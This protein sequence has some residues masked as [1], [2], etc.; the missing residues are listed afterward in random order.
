MNAQLPTTE[1]SGPPNVYPGFAHFALRALVPGTTA[2]CDIRLEAI[3]PNQQGPRLVL[4]LSRHAEVD[5]SWQQ[6]LLQS[7]VTHAFTPLED[8]D[9]LL[10]YLSRQS[11]LALTGPVGA[12]PMQGHYLAYEH[13][14]CSLKA[15]LLDPRNGRRLAL[16]AS[17]VRKLVGM[18][19]DND[20]TRQAMLKVLSRDQELA[21]HGLNTCLLAVGFA[22]SLGWS[23]LAA[24]RLGLAM[25]YHDLGLVD[26]AHDGPDDALWGGIREGKALEDH[27]RL[28]RDFLARIEDLDPGVPELVYNHHENL[29]GSGY[30]RGLAGEAIGLEVRAARIVDIY[31]TGSSGSRGHQA[32]NPYALLLVMRNEIGLWLDRPMLEKFVRFLGQF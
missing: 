8:L 25:F 28:G 32:M 22:R 19:W 17:T 4:A 6:R 3:Q 21:S 18:I 14:L 30:P 29:D 16:G 7:G 9:L 2:P 1:V 13:A 27:P 5:P 11:Q 12:D 10:A 26:L 23:R 31:E 24:E 15:A 20:T